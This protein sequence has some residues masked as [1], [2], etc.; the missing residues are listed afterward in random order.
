GPSLLGRWTRDRQ[1]TVLTGEVL[2]L[3]ISRP[4]GRS[5]SGEQRKCSH[6][7]PEIGTHRSR[8]GSA[9]RASHYTLDWTEHKPLVI[10]IAPFISKR[11]AENRESG[12]LWSG[13]AELTERVC[14][15]RHR[16]G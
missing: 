16:F 14:E 11:N 5:S 12:A 7:G 13:V 6:E 9:K 8:Q 3:N 15:R 4:R 1:F 2:P 10:R